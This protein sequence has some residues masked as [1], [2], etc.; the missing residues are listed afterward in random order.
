MVEFLGDDSHL[1]NDIDVYLMECRDAQ[2]AVQKLSLGQIE[3]QDLVSIRVTL[4]A[5]Q[6]IK[7]RMEDKIMITSTTKRKD[8]VPSLVKETLANINGLDHICELIRNVVD[9][10]MDQHQQYGFINEGYVLLL[11]LV[12]LVF[13][14]VIIDQDDIFV[15]AF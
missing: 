14:N 10:S 5:L 12:F 2:R 1:M 4:E 9:E 7:S 6:K 15:S 13:G 11:L 3:P 8:G